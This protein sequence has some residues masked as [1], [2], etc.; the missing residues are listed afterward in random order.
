MKWENDIK[1]IVIGNKKKF[2]TMR[3]QYSEELLF[4]IYRNQSCKIVRIAYKSIL[5]LVYSNESY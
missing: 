4:V 5:S 3:I 1:V 2:Y